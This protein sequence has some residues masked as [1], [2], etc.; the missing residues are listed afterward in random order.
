[1]RLNGLKL[2]FFVGI[3]ITMLLFHI[4]VYMMGKKIDWLN[5]VILTS[6][7]WYPVSEGLYPTVEG[8]RHL[9][10]HEV[11]TTLSTNPPLYTVRTLTVHS[12][13]SRDHQLHCGGHSLTPFFFTLLHTHACVHTY[14]RTQASHTS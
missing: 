5:N 4:R 8:R 2:S 6:L 10:S 7:S 1:M 13:E 11:L 3:L 14:T 12:T 9:H